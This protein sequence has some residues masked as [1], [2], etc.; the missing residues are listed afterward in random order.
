MP[1]TVSVEISG[2]PCAVIPWTQ[3]M[4]AQN[5][6][7]GAYAVL[8]NS[9][10]FTYTLQFYGA[11]LGYMVAMVNETYDSFISS[12]N[13]FFYWEFLLNGSPSSTGIDS[14]ILQAGDVLLFEFQQYDPA[15]HAGTGVGAKHAFNIR[16]S[17]H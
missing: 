1:A 12:A 17:A 11:Q 7:E 3:G 14:T 16:A 4:N 10:V 9:Q 8:N 5:A 2:G 15:R 13:P 6:L